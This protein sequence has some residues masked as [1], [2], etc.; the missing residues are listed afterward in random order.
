MAKK[1]KISQKC[2]ELLPGATLTNDELQKLFSVGNSGGMRKSNTFNCLI[3]ICDHSKSLYDDEWVEDELHYTGMGTK[4]DQSFSFAQNKTVNVS[5]DTDVALLLFE[6]FDGKK[7][8]TYHGECYLSGT[9]YQ[10]TQ[11]DQDK[12]IRTVCMFP[13]KL[14]HGDK[15][16]FPKDDLKKNYLDKER[17]A[18][19]LTDAELKQAVEAPELSSQKVDTTES[20]PGKTKSKYLRK[21]AVVEYALRRAGDDCQLCDEEAPFFRKNKTPFLEVHHVRWLS[22]KGP[23]AWH[24]VVALCPNCHR[25]MHALDIDSEIK[26]LEGLA[27][28]PL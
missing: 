22:R 21:P 3:I 13:L 23:D 16:V 17:K 7:P 11:L 20:K 6:R 2:P 28:I 15:I 26:K 5:G 27:S 25:R 1:H 14:K 10:A 24:N 9:P 12:N 4:G 8:Y 19:K 18:K